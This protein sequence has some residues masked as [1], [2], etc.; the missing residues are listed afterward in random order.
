MVLSGLSVT[1]PER[2]LVSYL[3]RVDGSLM[4]VNYLSRAMVY[5]LYAQ[6]RWFVSY[7]HMTVLSG[8]S[9]TYRELMIFSEIKTD[10]RDITGVKHRPNKTNKSIKYIICV[11]Y[12][13]LYHITCL[14][15]VR[16]TMQISSFILKEHLLL[17]FQ[18]IAILKTEN[19]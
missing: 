3:P 8:L 15:I 5:Q 1:C 18:E 16:K 17:T 10:S 9:V 2:W 19:Y 4:V 14:S 7:L 12:I 6:G 11:H 13:K